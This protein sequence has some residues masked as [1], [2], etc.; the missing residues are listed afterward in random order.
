MCSLYLSIQGRRAY[1]VHMSIS[2]SG[3]VPESASTIWLEWPPTIKDMARIYTSMRTSMYIYFY[4]YILLCIY[5]S[6]CIY[7]YAYF[8]VYIL[9]CVYTSM[10]IYFYVYILLCVRSMYIYFYA[11]F[12]VYI[13]LC[14][15]SIL[16]FIVRPM[17]I[18]IVSSLRSPLTLVS[19]RKR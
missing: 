7:F 6:M 10:Y 15:R 4:V 18:S 16:W 12:Y 5:T 9:L 3:Y 11:Y 19:P 14:I 13:L 8:Y 17:P 2:L 1:I